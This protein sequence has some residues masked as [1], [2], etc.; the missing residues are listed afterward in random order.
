M[1]RRVLSWQGDPG[2]VPP[3]GTPGPV[4]VI[5]P[6]YGAPDELKRCLASV[7]RHTDLARHRLVLVLDGPQP[8]EVAAVISATRCGP[9]AP[10]DPAVA[11]LM[12]AGSRDEF[13]SSGVAGAAIPASPAHNCLVLAAD[14]RKGFP[15]AANRGMAASDRDVVL[16]NSDTR[17][18]AGW[19]E[20]LQEA[21]YSA[22]EAA[23]VTP[24]SNAATICSLPRWLETNA[25]PAG[26]DDERF[27]RLVEERSLRTRPR[28]P[29]GVGV[30]LY[31]KRKALD[32]LGLL[33]AGRFGLGYGEEAEW[34][35][36]A[37]AAG[38]THLLDDATFVFHEGQGSFGT[39]RG[40]RV[41]HAHRVM[42]RLHPGYLPTIAAF[43]RQD[44][45]RPARERVVAE[46]QPPRRATAPGRPERVVH[47]VHGWPPWN[48]AGTELYAAWLARRQAEHRHVA[49]YA[50]ISDP[51]RDKG[52]A[53]EL[54]DAGA[55]V[56]LVVNDFRQRNPLS[57]NAILDRDFDRDFARLLDEERPQLV[58]VH[59]LAGH[60][61]SLVAVAGRRR[62]PVV[63]QLQDWWVPCARVNLF[64]RWRRACSGP[65]LAK[66]SRCLPLTGLPP[67]A[68]LNRVLYAWRSVALRRALR[69]ADAR[70][71]GSRAVVD[72]HRALGVL[73]ASDVVH[74]I[75]Y[76][77]EV[78]A[79]VP[80]R[81]GSTAAGR[82]LRFG[83][84]GSLLP[85][86]GVHVAAAA[87]CDID[88]AQASLTIWG[89]PGLD[90]EYAA[91]VQRLGP[92]EIRPPF[93][94]SEKP[95]VLAALD[96]LVVPSVGLESFGLAA[97]EAW[98]HGV[99]V[100]AS[101]RGALA[102]L[103]ESRP[104]AGATFPADD[105]SALRSWVDR[106]LAEPSLLDRWRAALPAVKTTAEHAEEIEQVYAEVLAARSRRR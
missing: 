28:L 56:R 102:E 25:L 68:L 87:F 55:R 89:D 94:E 29:T 7:T 60:A 48:A 18:T 106:I 20:K 70:V 103:W 44:P 19:L 80:R 14:Q 1:P 62:L 63:W 71:A 58:H 17:V 22:A 57:R 64:D 15:T 82:P 32:Q 36:R 35:M 101:D 76:G 67:A 43:L 98:H 79:P 24:F 95:S 83:I 54:L 51:R 46:L 97:R 12:T 42:R 23:T 45:L 90:P 84:F 10:G 105:A 96:V 75:P 93:P 72:S 16:L 100:L 11:G 91:E 77:V 4:D 69:R 66:C 99:P 39:T 85:H 26:W 27:G 47:V 41:R 5:V 8:P 52:D 37:L 73:R 21:A 13:V 31:I 2:R 49:V 40:P 30:C 38:Y 61:A 9:G 33:D 88:P 104:P 59:H 78:A 86:K 65:G 74:V 92:I 53:V 6:V 81:G 3:D 50:R 34:C